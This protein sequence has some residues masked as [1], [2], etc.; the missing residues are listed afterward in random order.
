MHLSLF[1]VYWNEQGKGFYI[2]NVGDDDDFDSALLGLH[3]GKELDYKGQV[4]AIY[5]SVDVLWYSLVKKTWGDIF[6]KDKED[7][8]GED[9]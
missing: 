9:G 4:R 1:E 3:L 7:G 8:D 5:F 6:H 2:L